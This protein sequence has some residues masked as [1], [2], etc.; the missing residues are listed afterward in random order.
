MGLAGIR[1]VG[2]VPEAEFRAAAAPEPIIIPV[3]NQ[4]KRVKIHIAASDCFS[5]VRA[6]QTERQVLRD[7]L[8]RWDGRESKLSVI[9]SPARVVRLMLREVVA[10]GDHEPIYSGGT[11][12][13]VLKFDIE[14]DRHNAQIWI[15]CKLSE[16]HLAWE[17]E[18]SLTL[19]ERHELKKSDY[20]QNGSKNTNDFRPEQHAALE[21]VAFVIYAFGAAI[22]GILAIVFWDGRGC[23]RWL[24]N[25]LG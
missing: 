20:R 18:G 4:A 6:P 23:W 7:F 11:F 5:C 24:V 13:T 15:E 3:L 10:D 14:F 25:A 2:D 12:P 22:I 19:N 16:R 9:H 21:I 17:H 8:I 1:P